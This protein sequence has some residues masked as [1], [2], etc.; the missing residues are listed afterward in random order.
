[1]KRYLVTLGVFL[2][3]VITL[4]IGSSLVAVSL[5]LV[6]IE[7]VVS[8]FNGIYASRDFRV[9]LGISGFV[10]AVLGFVIF[11]W[12]TLKM[13]REKTIAFTTPDGQ[14]TV[15]LEAIENFIRRV[16]KHLHGI[17]EIKP[18][19]V[20]NRKG[21]H[22]AARV[23]LFEETNI[24]EISEEI[25]RLVRKKIQDMLGIE[26]NIQTRVHIV[27]IISKEN[28]SGPKGTPGNEPLSEPVTP[29]RDY[30]EE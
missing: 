7:D 1:M 27:K 6:S 14:V 10:L 24:P 16:T 20:A 26:E 12:V 13:Q 18:D 9:M 23:T 15:S 11:Q 2:L 8:V 5:Q 29:Y 28:D 3:M 25:Q 19:V 17:K 21:L 4:L 30:P 22:V